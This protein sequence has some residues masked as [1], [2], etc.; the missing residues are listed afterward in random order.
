MKKR[1]L[2]PER[3]ADAAACGSSEAV[4][5]AKRELGMSVEE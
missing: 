4:S 5:T 3:N 1:L 2:A